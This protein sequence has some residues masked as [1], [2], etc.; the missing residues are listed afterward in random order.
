MWNL[1]SE[2]PT[3][4]DPTSTRK[5][6]E[7]L[8]F[9]R[10]MYCKTQVANDGQQDY[11]C[12]VSNYGDVTT[13]DTQDAIDAAA[14]GPPLAT[15]AM[16]FSRVESALGV[17]NEFDDVTAP[18]RT[19]KFYVYTGAGD[20][21]LRAANLDGK[22]ARPVPQLC[23]VCHGGAL[24]HPQTTVNGQPVPVFGARADVKLGSVFVPF[25]LRYYTFP[26]APNDKANP[27][28]QT[29][30][31]QLNQNIVSRVAQAVGDSAIKDV[32]DE[33][34]AG[35][36]A[37]Q[38]EDFSVGGWR[39]PA[40][41]EPAK[42]AFYKGALSNACRMCH[43]A[44]PF[45]TLRFETAVDFINQLPAVGARVCTQHVM[46][47]ANRTH[48]IFWGLADP[49]VV[50]PN[51]APHMAAQLQIFGVQFGP[52]ADW[53]GSAG[54]PPT[55]QCGTTFTSGG[56]TPLSYYEQNIQPLWS[57]AANGCTGCHPSNT[58]SG[59][60]GLGA[61]FSYGNLVGVASQELPAMSRIKKLDSNN[62]Y[63]Y[64]KLVGDQGAVGGS[65]VRM[66]AG[67]SA[68]SCVNASDMTTI[69]NWVD[70]RG[71]DGP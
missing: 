41:A 3:G 20:Q 15:V 9:G 58:G 10:D 26:P 46:P 12:Y 30:F 35:N 70:V 31:K 43:T 51:V 18:I 39:A 59:G 4:D 69:K 23:M 54:N 1:V 21:F 36:S 29:S 42:P 65:G 14:G 52:A 11:A 49:T 50:V 53:I 55:Y 25:D 16:E 68:N 5:R 27:S 63:L 13:A 19:V 56:S 40:V 47:H 6:V 34:Y 28:V 61:A 44:Q 22:G 48:E 7:C 60:L 37:I 8:G 38:L 24:P 45:Q 17:A 66:P 64:H 32:I 71:A 2:S 67:C 33:M 62:S 57:S